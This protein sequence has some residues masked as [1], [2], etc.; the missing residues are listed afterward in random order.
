MELDFLTGI[1][2]YFSILIGIDK[3]LFISN[4]VQLDSVDSLH[5]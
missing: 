5:M 3:A 1:L 4:V 2:K